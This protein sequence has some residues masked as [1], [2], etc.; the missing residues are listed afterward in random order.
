MV[1]GR[2]ASQQQPRQVGAGHQQDQPDRDRQKLQGVAEAVAKFGE[3][4]GRRLKLQ[5]FLRAKG[6]G[7]RVFGAQAFGQKAPEHRFKS[8]FHR[9]SGLP[10][11]NPS[12]QG[13]PGNA[14]L[15]Q[16]RLVPLGV[17]DVGVGVV[18]DL[19][20]H[21]DR[22]PH[23]GG[24]LD[25]DAGEAGLRHSHDRQHR[26]V[27]TNRPADDRPIRP[28]SPG[29]ER[30]A[31]DDDRLA[32]GGPGIVRPQQPA[33]RRLGPEQRK[34]IARHQ[35]A[36]DPFRGRLV[37]N[38]IHPDRTAHRP[39]PGS[40]R[41]GGPEPLESRP[42]EPQVRALGPHPLQVKQFRGPFD[43][44][45]AEEER[46]G[47]AEDGG[48]SAD[49]HRQRQHRRQREHRRLPKGAQGE[50]DIGGEVLH[51]PGAAHV[52]GLFL[53][54]LHSSQCEPGLAA[55]LGRR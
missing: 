23:I 38:E 28:E 2:V 15:A 36:R 29:P 12:H 31:Q 41:Q 47:H 30:V 13:Q 19:G 21:R 5:P 10:L 50:P 49:P 54:L 43:R 52:A 7:C 42:R 24:S 14:L 17:I 8:G 22:R 39:E 34:P 26:T 44:Q 3:P 32:A 35:L 27:E 40:G 11:R 4:S 25:P 37:G 51:P 6:P 33:D 20:L 18:L 45:R 1:P 9:S 53:H 48:V 16:P 55:S 46:I